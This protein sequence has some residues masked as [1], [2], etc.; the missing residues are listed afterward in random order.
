MMAKTKTKGGRTAKRRCSDH[1][2]ET[3]R[4]L[5]AWTGSG[6]VSRSSSDLHE[7]QFISR[8]KPKR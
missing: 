4:E 2:E 3:L 7:K 8:K 5:K 6:E 1:V